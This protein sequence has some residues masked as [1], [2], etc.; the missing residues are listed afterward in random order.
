M[1]MLPR[2]SSLARRSREALRGLICAA[3][4]ARVLRDEPVFKA[5]ACNCLRAASWLEAS[6][7]Q[8]LRAR[9]GK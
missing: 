1:P 3:A 8:Q 7:G 5:K 2:I 9:P 4:L 6:R